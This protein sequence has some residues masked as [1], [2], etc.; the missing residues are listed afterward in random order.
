MYD[1]S[2]PTVRVRARTRRQARRRAEVKAQQLLRQHRARWEWLDGDW[3]PI[4]LPKGGIMPWSKGEVVKPRGR[5]K[6]PKPFVW[7]KC[8]GGSQ[9][10]FAS[11]ISGPILQTIEAAPALADLFGKTTLSDG[12]TIPLAQFAY[13]RAR[14]T[15]RPV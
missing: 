1:P 10:A 15:W 4:P 6:A 5:R 7:P 11:F 2:W 9:E 14:P 8:L 3:Q 12:P 13:T